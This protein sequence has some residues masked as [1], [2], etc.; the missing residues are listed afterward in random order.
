M[1][2]IVYY[3]LPASH[4]CHSH[5]RLFKYTYS[6]KAAS[7]YECITALAIEFNQSIK[8]S[9]IDK[10]D[11]LPDTNASGLVPGML[12]LVLVLKDFL[13]TFFKSLSWSL[14]VRSLSWSL[15]SGP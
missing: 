8:Y 3:I 9:F 2:I 7:S 12:I 6:F 5:H 1:N 10:K 15:G 11:N 14:G 13:R 4:V